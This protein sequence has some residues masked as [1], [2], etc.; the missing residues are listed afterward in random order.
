LDTSAYIGP[1]KNITYPP[2][3][4]CPNTLA[5]GFC[6][7][8]GQAVAQ[9][10]CTADPACIGYGQASGSAVW[11]AAYPNGYQLYGAPSPAI[12]NNQWISYIKKRIVYV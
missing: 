6:I 9:G 8:T 10:V 4:E 7:L 12:T 5:P 11:L 1:A 3:G 2:L